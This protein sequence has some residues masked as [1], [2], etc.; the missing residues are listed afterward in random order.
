MPLEADG[1]VFSEPWE[2]RAFALVMALQEAGHFTLMEWA[3]ELS[4]EIARAG[5]AED[6]Y[7]CWVTALE[8]L[9][10]RKGFVSAA[11]L[12]DSMDVT[13]QAWPHPDHVARREPVARSMPFSCF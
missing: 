11:N 2:A 7:G 12:R 6:Y 9:L 3:S 4:V 1:A 8:T 10:A 13:R 5:Q